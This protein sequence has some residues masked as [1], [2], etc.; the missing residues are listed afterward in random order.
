MRQGDESKKVLISDKGR[1]VF[2]IE[3]DY[4]VISLPMKPWDQ[5]TATASAA[6]PAPAPTAGKKKAAAK[7]K[8]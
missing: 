1:P 6:A 4:L 8:K 2:Y 7:K 5:S 3:R